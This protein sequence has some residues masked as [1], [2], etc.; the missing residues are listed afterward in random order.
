M[1]WR[2][3]SLGEETWLY[4][5]G[6]KGV[7]IRSPKDKVKANDILGMTK[8]EYIDDI[9]SVDP[10]GDGRYM[11]PIAPSNVRD[12]IISKLQS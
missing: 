3:L 8:R 12:Y 6:Q 1:S 5:I 9:T 7:K 10:D 2:K 4:V 11:P